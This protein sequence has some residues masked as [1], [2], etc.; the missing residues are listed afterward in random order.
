MEK[1]LRVLSPCKL[2]AMPKISIVKRLQSDMLMIKQTRTRLRTEK[3]HVINLLAINYEQVARFWL[4][5]AAI[6]I[7]GLH[8]SSKS[9]LQ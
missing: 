7:A 5:L 3:K 6:N 8:V 1:D 4:L 9:T 2:E